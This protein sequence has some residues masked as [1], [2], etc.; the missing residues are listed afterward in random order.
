MILCDDGSS[1][2]KF[3]K[4]ITRMSDDGKYF[5]ALDNNNYVAYDSKGTSLN[6]EGLK[7]IDIYDEYFVGITSEGIL[8]I[9]DKT[10]KKITEEKIKKALRNHKRHRRACNQ[11]NLSGRMD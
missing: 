11:Y 8:N 4:K 1:V 2:G 3:D 9:Y 6:K 10:G 5:F 7:Y